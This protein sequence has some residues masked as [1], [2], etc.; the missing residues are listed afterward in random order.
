MTLSPS[1]ASGAR[2]LRRL[3]TAR[4]LF[5]RRTQS[6]SPSA[7]PETAEIRATFDSFDTDGSGSVSADELEAML[8]QL[9][10]TTGE[11]AEMVSQADTDK[12]GELDFDE[13]RT[14]INED[15]SYGSYGYSYGGWSSAYGPS[16]AEEKQLFDLFDTDKS[17]SIDTNELYAMLRQLGIDARV[18]QVQDYLDR[19]DSDHNGTLDYDEF[20]DLAKEL[21]QGSYASYYSYEG[22]ALPDEEALREIFDAF[23]TDGNGEMDASEFGASLE[24]LGYEGGDSDTLLRDLDK[25]ASSTLTFDEWRKLFEEQVEQQA[26]PPRDGCSDDPQ[27]SF[28]GGER[29][30][31]APATWRCNDWTG[32]NCAAG[33]FGVKTAAEIGALL[34]ACPS[35]CADGRCHNATAPSRILPVN[36]ARFELSQEGKECGSP[37][38]DRGLYGGASATGG[39]QE[40][41]NACYAADGCSFF[42][43]GLGSKAGRCYQETT[44]DES[45]PEGW[46][47]ADFNFYALR[48]LA[49][50]SPPRPPMRPLGSRRPRQ[51]SSPPRGATATTA[52]A[53]VSEE[54]GGIQGG[55]GGGG[56]FG[57]MLL[58]VLA[59]IGAFAA[60]R[61]W[62]R[63][64]GQRRLVDESIANVPLSSLAG[65]AQAVAPPFA[66]V[67]PPP[68][69]L[70]I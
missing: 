19:L 66:N 43:Y 9:G 53:V 47:A 51:P 1:A 44:S 14:L 41:A 5:R 63:P 60:Y 2:R 55:G 16:E 11:V 57:L 25:D 64:R 15:G 70:R 23:D 13:F 46:E 56:G 12:N 62:A 58:A 35:A 24:M 10:F 59:V 21:M 65:G 27:Y 69:S 33:G 18:A 67:V 37:N 48:D 8:G 28:A 3:T 52:A 6:N 22:A 30:D 4:R 38:L 42:L 54:S 40:C 49:P 20:K 68:A 7:D 26:K 39:L 32:Y 45:C 31:G 17:G 34:E 29:S 36:G 50:P 61:R